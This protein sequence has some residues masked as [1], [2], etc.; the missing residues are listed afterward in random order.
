M[1]KITD[2]IN[3]HQITAYFI[4]TYPFLWI[5]WITVQSFLVDR[6]ILLE[7]I[8]RLGIFGPAL[9]VRDSFA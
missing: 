9:S 1:Q 4:L 6:E 3:H 5:I 2:W 8:I 7:P